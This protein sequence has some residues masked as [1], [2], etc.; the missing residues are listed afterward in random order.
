[1]RTTATGTTDELTAARHATGRAT[2]DHVGVARPGTDHSDIGH[3]AALELSASDP[4][5][6][7]LLELCGQLARLAGAP[8]LG[9]R[10]SQCALTA[11]NV[12]VITAYGAI[13]ADDAPM[14]HEHLQDALQTAAVVL[15]DLTRT[16]VCDPAGLGVLTAARYQ[17]HASGIT[18]HLLE[19][20]GPGSAGSAAEGRFTEV[21]SVTPD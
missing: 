12:V 1:M 6:R 20:P 3:A 2:S 19:R 17:A 18:L 21:G 13:T 10:F 7:S 16:P 9:A 8:P 4:L 15:V 11:A 14:L 5:D